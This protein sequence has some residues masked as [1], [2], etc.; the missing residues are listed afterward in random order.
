MIAVLFTLNVPVSINFDRLE[1]RQAVLVPPEKMF[2]PENIEDFV[3]RLQDTEGGDFGREE[4][5]SAEAQETAG[6]PGEEARASDS[7]S[8]GS[9]YATGSEDSPGSAGGEAFFAD[10]A[11]L[12]SLRRPF[13]SESDLPPESILDFSL[14]FGKTQEILDEIDRARLEKSIKQLKHLRSG[15]FSIGFS[16]D[17][18]GLTGYSAGG[19]GQTA[20]ASFRIEDYDLTPWAEKVVNKIL[21]S[22]IIPYP[23][24]MKIKGVVGISA[25][26]DRDGEVM[27]ARVVNSSFVLLLDEAALKALRASS[28]FPALPKDFPQDKLEAFFEFHYGD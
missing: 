5:R 3:R 2:L 9:V 26:I 4:G 19:A 20:R 23:Q 22:W 8:P 27:S 10:L 11:S 18:P 14:D 1:V 7:I 12:F 13:K 21:I 15:F 28:P 17:S 16:K 6:T 24:E 25:V